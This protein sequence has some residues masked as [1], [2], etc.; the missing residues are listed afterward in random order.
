ML[1]KASRPAL[2]RLRSVLALAMIAIAATSLSVLVLLRAELYA[3]LPR[4]ATVDGI[5]RQR[6][7]S[8]RVEADALVLMAVNA[9]DSA[10][11]KE[12]TE[13]LEQLE[14]AHVSLR[15]RAAALSGNSESAELEERFD[16]AERELKIIHDV[17][18][19]ALGHA[20]AS[21]DLGAER[22]A[23][24]EATRAWVAKMD[25][26]NLSVARQ[27]G[28]YDTLF[29]ELPLVLAGAIILG[30]GLAWVFL[31]QPAIQLALD[32]TASLEEAQ[33]MAKLGSWSFDPVTGKIDWSSQIY[34][35]FGRDPAIGPPKYGEATSYYEPVDE[36]RLRAAVTH[37]METG[38][39]YALELRLR[40]PRNGIRV[41]RAEGRTLAAE[42]GTIVRLFGTVIDVTAAVEREAALQ[43]AHRYA[44][45]A[46][47][48]KTE[49]LAN[50]SHEI[51]T[52]MTAILGYVDLLA[53]R[54]ASPTEHRQY[55]STIR[56]SANHLL[57]IIND[58]L[59]V[60]KIDAGQMTVERISCSPASIALD[61]VALFRPYAEEKG[62]A[63]ALRF[64]GPIPQSI[65]SDP[66]RLKQIL[67]NLVG[68]AVKFTETGSVN[69]TVGLEGTAE[70]PLLRFDVKDSGIGM[71]AV[72]QEKLFRPFSQADSSTTR[73]FGGSGLGLN[74][75]NRLTTMLGGE[76]TVASVPRLGSIFT[77][78]VA[79]G[80]LDCI[81]LEDPLVE[82][83]E[84]SMPPPGLA[85]T[86]PLAL[87]GMHVLVAED[88]RDNQRLISL[89][90]RRAGAVVEVAENGQLAVDRLLHAAHLPRIDLVLMDMQMP[91][92]DG[93]AATTR[94]RGARYQGPIIGLTAHAMQ[95]DREKCLAVGCDDYVTKP[96]DTA[97]FF[98]AI[99]RHRGV[100]KTS[101]TTPL[102]SI[103]PAFLPSVPPGR[104]SLVP[105]S[106]GSRVSLSPLTARPSDPPLAFSDFDDEPE[107]AELIAAFV[108]ELPYRVARME[109]ALL[110]H[111]HA[112]LASLAHQ[113]KGA[114]GG[115]GF[116][117]ISD[118][119]AQLETIV[120][121][122]GET[123]AVIDGVAQ[124]VR[125]CRSSRV[126]PGAI[127][128]VA[129]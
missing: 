64:D 38:V 79:T 24:R 115:Y 101:E 32:A 85:P 86:V 112:T 97:L 47:Q 33:V 121:E 5:G 53:D 65:Q 99:A 111:D 48:A 2:V 31:C 23:L 55:V 37:S 67:S 22:L 88:G 7:L 100:R 118:A 51:R 80:S 36:E 124:L 17:S 45:L 116:P 60:S 78:R 98:A 61:V 89:H 73:R 114:G 90:L 95:G 20:T 13:T 113:L 42:D 128:A 84:R 21:E 63:I 74:I 14:R 87:A 52:P 50:M 72:E 27:R 44:E 126:R 68:N 102:L 66:T 59:D 122:N 9:D 109:A 76:I 10:A 77:A 43:M 105:S 56:R 41:I 16:D 40:Q 6:M 11:R 103:V 28:V 93:Y 94:L 71:S 1:S 107:M 25:A 104:V 91:I 96:I 12:L 119:A 15:G 39:G 19:R 62:L 82:H 108:T 35:I 81:R 30:L 127:V 34:A 110:D 70:Q 54:S 29:P 18:T 123:A 4:A 125:S 75:A 69:V 120:R 92:L 49:F 26:I 83:V 117:R 57:Q 8:Q 3:H 106:V 58:I 129:G 46:S